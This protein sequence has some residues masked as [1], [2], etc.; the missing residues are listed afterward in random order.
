M[1]NK[2]EDNVINTYTVTLENGNGDIITELI[3]A[4]SKRNSILAALEARNDKSFIA[5]EA[6]IK[7]DVTE[8]QYVKGE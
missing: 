7:D 8:M 3:L 1:A 2:I 6:T 4:D 5:I